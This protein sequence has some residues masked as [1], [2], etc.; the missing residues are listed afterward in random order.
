MSETISQDVVTDLAKSFA[1]QVS[2]NRIPP[3]KPP[4][5]NGDPLKYASWKVAFETH[6]YSRPI[7]YVDFIKQCLSAMKTIKNLNVLNDDRENRKLLSK[8]PDWIVTRWGRIVAQHKSDHQTFPSFHTFS[9]F[10]ERE[11][12]IANDPVS[13]L[14]SLKTESTPRNTDTNFRSV[15]N[16]RDTQRRN[17][18]ATET[19]STSYDRTKESNSGTNKNCLFCQKAG[20]T[21]D[22]CRNYLAKSVQEQHE[23]LVYALLYTQSDTT[24]ILD[25]TRQSLG[26]SSADVKL[27]LSTMH[28][29][30]SVVDSCKIDGLI[31]RAYDSDLKIPLPSTF[32]RDILPANRAHIPTGDLAR[33]WPQLEKIANRLM[34]VIDCEF[35]LLI[36]YNC[37]RACFDS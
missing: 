8:L 28:S 1:D 32:A 29:Q 18:F 13:S 36:G 30:N 35:R 23:I 31:V 3:P 19:K 34:P 16:D 15:K 9:L 24:F 4:I 37:L 22:S 26:L 17:A 12:T 11:S 27:S 14:N 5:F 6:L 20:H 7:T 25:N 2:L 33:S 10:I 21:L